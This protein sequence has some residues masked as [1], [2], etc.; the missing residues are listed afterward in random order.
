MD[1]APGSRTNSYRAASAWS[2][3]DDYETALLLEI[4]RHAKLTVWA[5]EGPEAGFAI[6]LWSPGAERIYGY[7]PG[8]ARGRNYIDLFVNPKERAK[9]VEDHPR[10]VQTGEEYIWDFAADDIAK[11][12][13]IVTMLTN[14]FRV[15]DPQL[16]KY[17]LAEVGVDI[18]SLDRSMQQLRRLQEASLQREA[19]RQ[20][21]QMLAAFN[22]VD[23]TVA[24]LTELGSEGIGSVVSAIGRAVRQLVAQQP[25]C[26]VWLI[27]P[28]SSY[29]AEQSDPLPERSVI[30]EE[31][32]IT[33]LRNS[34]EPLFFD[35][36]RE[37]PPFK[38]RR[39]RRGEGASFAV[40][41]LLLGAELIGGLIVSFRTNRGIPS[42]E[43]DLLTH[44]GTHAGV[45]L[46]MARLTAELADRRREETART[47][48]NTTQ[49]IISS[50]L[51]TVGNDAAGL[52]LSAEGLR[53]ELDA[54]QIPDTA[55]QYLQVITELSERLSHMMDEFQ[56]LR[57]TADKRARFDLAE[58][59]S[60]ITRPLRLDHPRVQIEQH[61]PDGLQLEGSEPLL[62][63]ALLNLVLNA[64]Q[65]MEETDLGGELRISARTSPS[66]KSLVEIDVEDS[67]P[68]VPLIEHE[69][70]GAMV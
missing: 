23:T 28:R 64:V 33:W 45:A 39:R 7:T 35:S 26:R 40:L 12:G 68:G 36:R 34:S 25:A 32:V 63:E 62:R 30:D 38:L 8:E 6:R 46:A 3:D 19:G 4:L 70:I 11:D 5:A 65:A 22:T 55:R 1:E 61:V 14:C 17:L 44:F 31:E 53:N 37:D 58:L 43:R 47:R 59:I 21:V 18:S 9:A 15:W 50:M 54:K 2:A 24:S 67:G 41:P 16:S 20:R 42:E 56:Q 48:A 60:T 51:H 13:S 10:M 57:E 29:L 66:N 69:R 52:K 49:A 27:S